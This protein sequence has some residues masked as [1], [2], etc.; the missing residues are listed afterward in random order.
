VELSS[1]VLRGAG[2]PRPAAVTRPEPPAALPPG[3]DEPPANGVGTPSAQE[4]LRSAREAIQAIKDWLP[5]PVRTNL[6]FRVEEEL[7]R[8]VVSVLDARSGDLLRQIPADV[9][10]RVARN[11]QEFMRMSGL[12]D[13][14]A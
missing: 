1:V 14:V 3:Q 8:V 7:D 10:L 4:S 12:V 13:E 9:A 2:D 6:T 5:E 11:L